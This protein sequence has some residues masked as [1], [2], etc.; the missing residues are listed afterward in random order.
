MDQNIRASLQIS[1]FYNLQIVV[2]LTTIQVN[3]LC[4]MAIVFGDLSGKEQCSS[5]FSC[6]TNT[7]W[8]IWYY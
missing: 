5:C 2:V 3:Q 8:S 4:L 1:A 7:S 6:G